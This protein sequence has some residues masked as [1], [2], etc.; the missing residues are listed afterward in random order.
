[1]KNPII[2]M[3]KKDQRIAYRAASAAYETPR[4]LCYD[5]WEAYEKPSVYKVRAWNRCKELCHSLSGWGLA[6]T[7][8]N[9][10]TFSVVFQYSDPDTGE[11]CYAYIT[12]DYDRFCYAS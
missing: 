5:I 6:I 4:Y 8:H 12:K 10:M 7:G 3:S 1:M 9:S 11:L 2:N